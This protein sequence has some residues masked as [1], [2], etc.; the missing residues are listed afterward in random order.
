MRLS[1]FIRL[2]APVALGVLLCAPPVLAGPPQVY[3]AWHCSND[4]CVW[5]TPRAITEFD[6]MNHWLIDVFAPPRHD[7][8]ERPGWVRNADEYPM[9]A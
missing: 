2:L 1:L 9:P 7:F 3:G 8:S 4:A 5:G 6:A